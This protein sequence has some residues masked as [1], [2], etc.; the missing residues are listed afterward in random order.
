MTN[1]DDQ[2]VIGVIGGSGTY[3]IPGVQVKNE[4]NLDTPFGSPSDV[5]SE[6]SL[7]D[8]S[9][10]FLPRHGKKH[11]LTPSEVPYRANIHAMRQLGVTHLLAVSAVGIMSEAIKPGDLVIPDQLFDHTKGIRSSTFFGEGVVGHISF[12][13]P[14]CLDFAKHINTVAS[15]CQLDTHFGGT[16]VCIEGPRFSSRTESNYFRKVLNPSIIG[17]TAC[18]E[19]SLAR[20]AQLS[21]AL[22]GLATDYD[23]WHEEEEDVSVELVL[24]ALKQAS[25]KSQTIIKHLISSMPKQLPKPYA[26]TYKKFIMNQADMIPKQSKDNLVDLYNW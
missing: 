4:H 15:E 13:D 26:D 11:C 17:M 5:I 1:A 21:Y 12:A 23:C 3:K 24:K 16:Y 18:P 2:C 25:A 10:F 22:L 8:R 14:F 19:A 20:E 7:E 6:C 9:F